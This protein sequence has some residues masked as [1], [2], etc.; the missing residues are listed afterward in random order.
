MM[1][2]SEN[3]AGVTLL[4]FGRAPSVIAGLKS[5][6]SATR[7]AYTDTLGGAI[8]VLFVV[9]GAVIICQPFHTS[10][11]SFLRD[12]GFTLLSV[13][14]IHYCYDSE[15]SVTLIE[16]IRKIYIITFALKPFLF[17]TIIGGGRVVGIVG[18]VSVV[19]FPE[20]DYFL[21]NHTKRLTK[22][23]KYVQS[24][25]SKSLVVN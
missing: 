22:L 20:Y 11:P 2:L 6:G 15:Y 24:L 23:I 9:G 25:I 12:C 7:I 21:S 4:A 16:A 19:S 3:V 17:H 18:V 1:G 14:F 5:L 8:F 10:P 13:L